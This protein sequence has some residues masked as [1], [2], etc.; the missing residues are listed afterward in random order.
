MLDSIRLL[1]G[2]AVRGVFQDASCIGIDV[3]FNRDAIW[4]AC[5]AVLKTPGGKAVA[6]LLVPQEGF[7]VRVIPMADVAVEEGRRV[8]GSE[9]AFHKL[10][11]CVFFS[12][13]S[14]EFIDQVCRVSGG[15]QKGRGLPFERVHR[16]SERSELIY[17]QFDIREPSLGRRSLF[18]NYSMVQ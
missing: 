8:D 14:L 12:A 17:C 4:T 7:L 9:R 13:V 6:P 5:R 15:Y 1:D 18:A 3:E 11:L 10:F 2:N 16:T